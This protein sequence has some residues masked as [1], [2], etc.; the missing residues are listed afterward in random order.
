MLG[1]IAACGTLK[2][3]K[4][5]HM[6]RILIL[7]TVQFNISYVADDNNRTVSEQKLGIRWLRVISICS[8]DIFPSLSFKLIPSV[9]LL[10]I[11]DSLVKVR[12]QGV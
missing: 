12:G 2:N 9:Y 3:P 4:W 5:S 1:I 7:K 10:I 8:A 11:L 6:F